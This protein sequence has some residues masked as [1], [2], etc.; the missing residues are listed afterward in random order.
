[1]LPEATE[2]LCSLYALSSQVDVEQGA[3]IDLPCELIARS[4]LSQYEVPS[5][6][7]SHLVAHLL[8]LA[9]RRGG[10]SPHVS[11]VQCISPLRLVGSVI[12]HVHVVV[13]L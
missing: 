13:V 3:H 1:M 4:S 5:L 11:L 12:S 8:W 9:R 2:W 10:R 7:W 6:A